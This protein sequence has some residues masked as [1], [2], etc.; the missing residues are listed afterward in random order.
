MPEL[1]YYDNDELNTGFVFTSLEDLSI[2]EDIAGSYLTVQYASRKKEYKPIQ[3]R[4]AH[5]KRFREE[6]RLSPQFI[7]D[8]L[9][10]A[11][12]LNLK[13]KINLEVNNVS[14]E[15]L[16]DGLVANLDEHPEHIA[17]MGEHVER[18]Q[19][20]A[21]IQ[22]LFDA[23]ARENLK[24]D[25]FPEMR[26]VGRIK[27]AIHYF[28]KMR[29][30]HQFTSATT[31]AQIITLNTENRQYFIDT[32][33]RAKEIYNMNV[34]KQKKELETL[35]E[36]EI[37]SSRNYKNRFAEVKYKKSILQPFLEAKDARKTIS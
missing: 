24:P 16:S 30:P 6:T 5:L 3:L 7:R 15:M 34:G 20:V 23:F 11:D 4:S 18:E 1:K 31:R 33:N 9:T 37:P 17:E 29:F 12:E 13:G 27:D 19:N 26:S 21:E 32:I 28:F 14:I 10:A 8:F 2:V 35:E 36:W 25:F 22:K